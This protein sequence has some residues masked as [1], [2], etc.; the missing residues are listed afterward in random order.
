MSFRPRIKAI[1]RLGDSSGFVAE[2]VEIA[3]VT[4]GPTWN[5]TL[6]NLREAIELHLDLDGET[7]FRLDVRY[8]C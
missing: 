6:R 1:I 2:C 3:V 5:E 8:E 4:Q 7:A